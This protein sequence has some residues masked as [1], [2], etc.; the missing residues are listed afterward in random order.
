[1]Q[2]T[3]EGWSQERGR[4]QEK[5]SFDTSRSDHEI[6]W[7]DGKVC[8]QLTPFQA[9]TADW[10]CDG[11]VYTE[12]GAHFES[13]YGAGRDWYTPLELLSLMLEGKATIPGFKKL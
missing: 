7:K 3:H 11:D 5:Y 8:K 9:V 4:F 6:N 1:M 10:N 2:L 12:T 13:Q